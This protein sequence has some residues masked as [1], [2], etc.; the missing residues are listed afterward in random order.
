M[1]TV[2]VAILVFYLITWHSARLQITRLP[3]P[4][5]SESFC[6]SSGDK[7]VSPTSLACVWKEN[8]HMHYVNQRIVQETASY[9]VLPLGSNVQTSDSI[10]IC[11]PSYPSGPHSYSFNGRGAHRFVPVTVLLLWSEYPSR[12]FFVCVPPLRWEMKLHRLT[13]QQVHF[14]Y[15]YIDSLNKLIKNTYTTSVSP[16]SAFGATVLWT[17]QRA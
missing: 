12:H 13:K 4:Q 7:I 11:Y 8:K 5:F 1:R 10:P 3:F 6:Y 14:I 2:Y 17:T 9:E 16:R 15:I